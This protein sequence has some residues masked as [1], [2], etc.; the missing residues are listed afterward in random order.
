MK[1]IF[2]DLDGVLI[3][4][5]GAHVYGWKK[6]LNEFGYKAPASELRLMGGVSYRDTILHFAKANGKKVTASEM[7]II[8]NR[9]KEIVREKDSLIKVFD[10]LSDLKELKRSKI[11]LLVVTGSIRRFVEVEVRQHFP[12]IFDDI[13][14]FDDV[15]RGKPYPDPYLEALKRIGF[16]K[17]ECVIVEDAPMGVDSGKAAGIK[18][19]GITTSLPKKYLAKADLVFNNHKSLFKYLKNNL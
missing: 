13:V 18:V 19:L 3:D 10:I 16:K 14:C 8:Y 2:F 12:K 11:K 1:A 15:K 6:A 7:E 5:M 4:S 9:K 17:E